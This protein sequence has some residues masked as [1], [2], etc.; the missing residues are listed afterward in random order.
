M[1]TTA[2][3]HNGS[4][5]KGGDVFGKVSKVLAAIAILGM[6][7]IIGYVGFQNATKSTSTQQGGNAGAN[8]TAVDPN[9]VGGRGGLTEL[10]VQQS[11][12]DFTDDE[13]TWHIWQG[14]ERTMQFNVDVYIP[15]SHAALTH[16]A[17]EM[18]AALRACS[19]NGTVGVLS[20]NVNRRLHLLCVDPDTKKE[21]V[22]IIRTLK[23]SV[24]AF[25]NTTSELVTAFELK[26]GATQSNI[27]A[28]IHGEV[29][30]TKTAI[31]VR[32]GW[33]AGELFFSP[34]R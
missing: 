12:I 24:D 14:T 7:L 4:G 29:N 16:G 15:S 32:L 2:T 28:Y 18:N 31:L 33:K 3:N 1:V 10:E 5:N 13:W 19:Q 20:E 26:A 27:A 23:R 9:V 22:V 34:Y 8:P 11:T 30:L 25:K 6:F 21:Y 17:D